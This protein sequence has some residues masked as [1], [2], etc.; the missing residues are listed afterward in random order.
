MNGYGAVIGAVDTL[1]AG[2]NTNGLGSSGALDCDGWSESLLQSL[3]AA[4][5]KVGEVAYANGSRL[6]GM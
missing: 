2:G 1:V 6:Y 4:V 5:G 3:E